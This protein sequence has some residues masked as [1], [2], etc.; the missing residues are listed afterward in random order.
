MVVCD[1]GEVVVVEGAIW[2][3]VGGVDE[4]VGGHTCA[5]GVELVDVENVVA[6]HEGLCVG[7][8]PCVIDFVSGGL[9][10]MRRMMRLWV[11]WRGRR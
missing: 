6:L 4:G 7:V 5:E 2:L 8:V 10:K 11:R 9:L 1:V 3:V